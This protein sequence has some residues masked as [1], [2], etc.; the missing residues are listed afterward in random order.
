MDINP[1]LGAGL[2]AVFIPH[3]DTWILEHEALLRPDEADRL[4]E[5]N[6]FSD[7]RGVF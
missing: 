2:K 4:M 3:S 7:L 1:A 6:R 5:L